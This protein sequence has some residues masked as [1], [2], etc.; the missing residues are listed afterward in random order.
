MKR[1]HLAGALLVVVAVGLPYSCGVWERSRLGECTRQIQPA[2]A[3]EGDTSP[4]YIGEICFLGSE[5]SLLFRLYDARS[6][7]LLAERSYYDTDVEMVW[8]DTKIWYSSDAHVNLPPTWWD[9][10]RAKLP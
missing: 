7:V 9:R 10:L 5:F 4:E 3:R 8:G 1:R 2:F 6:G